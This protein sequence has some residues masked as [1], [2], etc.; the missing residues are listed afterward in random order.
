VK[1]QFVQPPKPLQ[2]N[3]LFASIPN[4]SGRNSAAWLVGQWNRL[5]EIAPNSQQFSRSLMAM[6]YSVGKAST[7]ATGHDVGLLSDGNGPASHQ[8]WPCSWRLF[9][10]NNRLLGE[11]FQRKTISAFQDHLGSA[12]DDGGKQGMQNGTR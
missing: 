12:L 10:S 11:I 6:P 8:N 9:R 1:L 4:K 2:F 7:K 3:A 5:M